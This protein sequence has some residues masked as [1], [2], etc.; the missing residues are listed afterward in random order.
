MQRLSTTNLRVEYSH[1]RTDRAVGLYH[2]FFLSLAYRRSYFL[3]SI[4]IQRSTFRLGASLDAHVRSCTR[5]PTQS[6]TSPI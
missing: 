3:G 6:E 4:V 2:P 5:P 1:L